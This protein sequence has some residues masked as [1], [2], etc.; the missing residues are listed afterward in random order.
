MAPP[1][2]A[3]GVWAL[4]GTAFLTWEFHPLDSLCN[5]GPSFYMMQ[6]P[7]FHVYL[8]GWM[9]HHKEYRLDKLFT[10]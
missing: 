2:E 4:P 10:H 7:V 5:N 3:I 8:H 9:I 6:C 1:K